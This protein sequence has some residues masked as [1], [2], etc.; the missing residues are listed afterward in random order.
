MLEDGLIRYTK[1]IVFLC[2]CWWRKLMRRS[3]VESD[4][5]LVKEKMQ[6]FNKGQ[7]RS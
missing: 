2:I 1:V 4:E 6:L 7:R 3:N 5:K